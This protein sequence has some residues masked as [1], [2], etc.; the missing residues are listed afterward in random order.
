MGD[1]RQ[2]ALIGLAEGGIIEMNITLRVDP[3]EKKYNPRDKKI[4]VRFKGNYFENRITNISLE[5]EFKKNNNT[6]LLLV[7]DI[8]NYHFEKGR[9]GNDYYISNVSAPEKHL[10]IDLKKDGWTLTRI[11][12][13]NPFCGDMAVAA[14]GA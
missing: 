13:K 1:Q 6:P 2:S 8:K 12:V 11:I 7:P 5:W 4:M 14:G 9:S 3:V 10:N